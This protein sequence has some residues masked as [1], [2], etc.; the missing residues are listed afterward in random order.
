MK[1]A[2]II[3]LM[4]ILL[5]SCKSRVDLGYYPENSGSET[6]E[7][8]FNA[9]IGGFFQAAL[10]S[11]PSD[12]GEKM[13]HRIY[14]DGI[15][16]VFYTTDKDDPTQPD[17]VAYVFDKDIKAIAGSFSGTDYLP[18][19]IESNEGINFRVKGSEKIVVGDYLVYYFTS[20]NDQLKNATSVGKP[21]SEITG[22]LNYDPEKDFNK[23][24]LKNNI[25]YN[26]EPIKVIKSLFDSKSSIHK[27]YQLPTAKLTA[28]NAALSVKWKKEVKDQRYEIEG[29]KILVIPDVQNLKYLLFPKADEHLQSKFQIYYPIDP[30][31]GG[32]ANKSVDELKSEFLYY[33]YGSGYLGKWSNH[34]S[35]DLS[36]YLLIPENTVASSETSAKVI[37][38]VILLVR[39]IP[40]SLKEQLAQKEAGGTKHGWVNYN[41]KQY[42]D[43]DFENI[44]QSLR[45]KST[46]TDEEK[47]FI[48]VGSRIMQSGKNALIPDGYEDNDI[49]YYNRS[50]CYYAFPITHSSLDAVGGTT[51]NGGYFGVVRNHHYEYAINSFSS[52]G[53]AS[54]KYLSY[55]LDYL[56]DRFISSN[57]EIGD[58]KEVINEIDEL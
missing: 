56:S 7:V 34:D 1:K 46:L 49:Q 54:T 10:K 24:Q 20:C 41:R 53:K 13:K 9:L 25:Y 12:A 47:E 40:K 58:M 52:I 55:D 18:S 42:I 36:P 30:N 22:T 4:T 21:F 8:S 23:G 3:I 44:Y 45:K 6:A 5:G 51:D 32:F 33:Y 27:T 28:I 39:I 43:N 31:Y 17:K 15:R 48:A 37:T 14:F 35:S 38:R 19:L 11:Y 57:C 50:Y 16:I 2:L 26:S 29:D